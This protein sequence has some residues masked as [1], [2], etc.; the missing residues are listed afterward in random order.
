MAP[1]SEGRAT[2]LKEFLYV[3]LMDMADLNL[4]E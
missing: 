3:M 2:K 1:A 4:G